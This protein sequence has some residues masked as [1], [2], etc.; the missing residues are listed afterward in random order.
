[1]ALTSL[2]AVILAG[3]LIGA[4]G[5]GGVLLVPVLTSIEGLAPAQ[6]IAASS[7]AFGFPGLAALWYLNRNRDHMRKTM[8]VVIG[9]MPG[10][11]LGAVLVHGLDSRIV[12]ILV[13]V[14]ICFAGL[15]GLLAKRITTEETTQKLLARSALA[16]IGLLAGLGSALTGTG[17]PVLLIPVLL[18]FHQP[19]RLAIMVGQAVQLPIALSAILVHARAG[20]LDWVLGGTLGLLLLIASVAGQWT[21]R[22]I[23]VPLLQK[24]LSVLLLLIGAWFSYLLFS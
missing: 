11:A 6:A 15:R 18:L 7:M 5:I 14:T 13:I 22:R 16:G 8:P 2:L 20:S 24:A 12:L 19:I 10:A 1:M 17:G 4:T 23:Q 9:A 3:F 21:T